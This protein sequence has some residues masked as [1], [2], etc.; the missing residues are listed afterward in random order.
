MTASQFPKFPLTLFFIFLASLGWA[1]EDA[2]EGDDHVLFSTYLP[3]EFDGSPVASVLFPNGS[4]L[5][6]VNPWDQDAEGFLLRLEINPPRLEK[7]GTFPGQIRDMTLMSGMVYVTGTG[8]TRSLRIGPATPMRTWTDQSGREVNGVLRNVFPDAIELEVSG[9]TFRVPMDILSEEDREYLQTGVLMP[10]TWRDREDRTLWGLLQRVNGDTITLQTGHRTVQIALD[11]LSDEDVA[12]V[13]VFAAATGATTEWESETGGDRLSPGPD[14]TVYLLSNRTI[15]HLGR[16]GQEIRHWTVQATR[17]GDIVYDPKSNLVFVTGFNNRSG[18]FRDRGN[19]PI[20]VV[21]VHA[22]TP[23]G[24]SA[25]NAYGFSGQAVLDQILE[26]DTRGYHMVMGEDGLL[27]LGGESAGGA[28]LWYRSSKDV[29]KEIPFY[30]GDQFQNWFNTR[31]NHITSVVT[32]DP[33]TGDSLNGT[34]ILARSTPPE[35]GPAA[36]NTIRP[37]TMAAL[38]GG[39]V[40]VGGASA[41]RAPVDQPAFGA[42]H[43]GGAFLVGLRKDFTRVYATNLSL[44]GETNHVSTSPAGILVI[45]HTSREIRVVHPIGT[46]SPLEEGQRRGWVTFFKPWIEEE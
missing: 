24:E 38:P 33:K 41:Y 34:M 7:A 35:R 21:F 14:G 44:G 3:A 18:R 31:S 10:R 16:D 6:A 1:T 43:G 19:W 29:T 28:T 37:R 46:P 15:Y 27:Y 40:V 30:R 12:Y 26:A 25:W 20:Q 23:E 9:R 45:G 13:E 22:F 8:G 32:L 5:I 42:F 39:S 4:A 17:T 36:G 2:Q 11:T